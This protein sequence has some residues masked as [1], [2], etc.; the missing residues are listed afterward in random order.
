[1]CRH[2]TQHVP[3][4]STRMPFLAWSPTSFFS[5]LRVRVTQ[6]SFILLVL[7]CLRTC[8]CCVFLL[9]WSSCSGIILAMLSQLPVAL[10]K[11]MQDALSIV[12]TVRMENRQLFLAFLNH[13]VWSSQPVTSRHL[14][15]HAQPQVFD[16][17]GVLCASKLFSAVLLFLLS[18]AACMANEEKRD[19]DNKG[20]STVL[21][22]ENGGEANEENDEV[23]IASSWKLRSKMFFALLFGTVATFRAALNIVSTRFT[24]SCY[25]SKQV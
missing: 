11:G 23:E 3:T 21:T 17:Q 7:Q 25:T 2:A 9:H 16:G 8:S 5:S 15:V 14:Q 1:M 20:E 19:A 13:A 24:V 4:D 18:H 6:R 12:G 22:T 10:C